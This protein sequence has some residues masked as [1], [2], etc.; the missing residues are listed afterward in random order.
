[1]PWLGYSA[2]TRNAPKLTDDAAGGWQGETGER[3]LAT[4]TDVALIG[5]VGSGWR[6]RMDL[7]NSLNLFISLPCLGKAR[8]GARLQHVMP[9]KDRE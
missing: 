8:M 5:C 1:M 4:V 7:L 2:C 6:W 3:N 9:C